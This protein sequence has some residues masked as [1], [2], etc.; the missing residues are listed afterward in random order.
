MCQK[1]SEITNF[2]YSLLKF[3]SFVIEFVHAPL[4]LTCVFRIYRCDSSLLKHMLEKI[5]YI[6]CL[7][8][9]TLLWW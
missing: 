6:P 7:L 5:R 3:Y 1:R 2:S 4:C 9:M 8:V